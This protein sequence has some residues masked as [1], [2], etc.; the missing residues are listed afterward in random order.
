MRRLALAGISVLTVLLA[1]GPAAPAG[2]TA[3]TPLS[4]R[5]Y[6]VHV[7]KNVH[8]D[9][10]PPLQDMV[11]SGTP[12]TAHPALRAPSTAAP[13][14]RA[15]D[16]GRARHHLTPSPTAN[17][18]GISANGSAPPDTQGAAGSL[19]QYFEMANT[20]IAVYSK[21]GSVL[22]GPV[23]TNTLWSGFGGGCQ[24]NNDGDGVV[25]WDSMSSRWVISQF[26][27][28]TTPYLECVAVSTTSD[29][30]GTYNRYS[31]SYTNFPDYPKMGVWPDAYYVSLNLFNA[32][33]TQALG[34]MLCAYD[35]AKMLTGAA[36]TQQCFQPYTTGEH[37]QLPASLDGSTQPPAG[38]VEYFTG[39][40][41]TANNLTY[42]KFHVDW[43]VPGNSTLTGP[44]NLAVSAYSRACNGGGTCIPQSG[45][46]TQLDSL[47]DRVMARLAYRNLGSSE[48]LV[49]THSITSGS[50]VGARWYELRVSGGNLTVFQQGTFAPDSAYRWMGST[51]M[52]K[53]GDIALGYSISSSATHPGIRYT[54]RVPGD[55]LGTMEAEVTAFTGAGS[56]TGGLTRWGDYSAMSV[57]PVDDCT[58]WYTTEYIPANG[59]FNWHTRIVSFKF[60]TC[61]GTQTNDFSISANPSSM[62]VTQGGSGTSTISTTVTQGQSQSVSLSASGLPTGA[63]A[64]FVPNPIN[65]GS[66]STLTITTSPTTPT[67]TSTVTVTGTGPNATHSTS[68]T[69]TVN[70]SGGGSGITNGGFETG[71]FSGW[72]TTGTTSISTT[73]PHSGTY[74]AQIGST[75][76]TSGDSTAAQTFTAPTGATTLAFWYKVVCPDTLTYDWATVTLKDNT[77]GT[78]T[79]PLPKTCT[80]NGTWKQVTTSIVAGDNY[81]ITLISH[82]D[83]YPGDATY[84]YYDDVA[85]STS[86]NVVQNGGF[87]TGTFSP[88]TTG[89]T[90][91]P[92]VQSGG[93]HSG[94]Y[95]AK[96]GSSSPYSGDSFFQQTVT[97]PSTGGT[98]TFWYQPH[99]TDT[100]TYD[101]ER[102]E[103]RST[104]GSTLATVLNVCSNSGAWTQVTYGMAAYAGQTV[105]LWFDNHDDNYPS[106]PT[107]TLVDD[108]SLQ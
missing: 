92:V 99:C 14:V 70:P 13:V 53:S 80:N 59:S 55:A 58:F 52:D 43:A 108:V 107:Y 45:T 84:T 63:T 74:S 12:G 95:T 75:A 41:D 37:T 54:G 33:G 7:W 61:G 36:A 23:N 82:D 69:L 56:Q 38:S 39:L 17:F 18:D 93:A 48:S 29:A 76:P 64:S 102:M 21:T 4:A 27:V 81:T 73:S 105:V 85:T 86:V 89:G 3:A 11:D 72:S 50:S 104:G 97:V 98:L 28:S 40:S 62:T 24:T 78:T 91:L 35:R 30:L 96:M 6:Q 60:T 90:V 88:W 66:S 77:K 47:G 19:N 9:V 22:Y 8:H 46:T 49:V 1:A 79:T 42:F 26:S 31:F 57:D 103:I 2:A 20:R 16:T 71:T 15:G 68:I 106:D 100:I 67:G 5:A 32:G 101:W 34:T 25:L 10:S 83:N 65:S 87:E 44:T 94:T 51:A